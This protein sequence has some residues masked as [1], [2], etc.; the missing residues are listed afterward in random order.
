MNDVQLA[1]VEVVF[2]NLM[3]ILRFN[4]GKGCIVQVTRTGPSLSFSIKLFP[5]E[6]V[7]ASCR[8][9]RYKCVV[10]LQ[11]YSLVYEYNYFR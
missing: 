11:R 5:F 8:N 1:G 7:Y 4:S 3:V 10:L 6:K 9:K 2:D